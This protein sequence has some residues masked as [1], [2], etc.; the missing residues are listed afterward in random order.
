MK[1]KVELKKDAIGIKG[2]L[3]V[4]NHPGELV[5]F[6]NLIKKEVVAVA[7]TVANRIPYCPHCKSPNVE[8]L[9]LNLSTNQKSRVKCIKCEK[10]GN[11]A[12]WI[13][14]YVELFDIHT[15]PE[16]RGKGYAKELVDRIMN[17]CDVLVTSWDDSTDEGRKFCQSRGMIRNGNWLQWNKC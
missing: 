16:H 14:I 5:F 8:E 6:Q 9:K 15:F 2:S 1:K 17:A 13:K 4:I 7:K 12:D 3:V 10:T 11:K